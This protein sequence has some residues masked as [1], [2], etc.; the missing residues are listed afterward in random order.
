MNV[1]KKI[2]VFIVSLIVL[3]LLFNF[4]LNFW[5]NK[6]LPKIISEKNKTAYN[7]TYGDLQIDLLAKNIKASKINISPKRSCSSST[8]KSK[9]S[10]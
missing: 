8:C 9:F 3:I 1:Y 10:S 6:Q 2:A 4:G 5:V 7:I